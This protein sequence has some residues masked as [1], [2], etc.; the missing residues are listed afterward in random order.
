MRVDFSKWLNPGALRH[1]GY[2]QQL[3]EGAQDSFGVPAKV[4]ST[5]QQVQAR[6]TALRGSELDTVQQKWAD[7]RF[8][9]ELHY[10]AG[11][12]RKMRFVWGDLDGDGQPLSAARV[13]D[14]LDAEDPYGTGAWLVMYC[15][16]WAE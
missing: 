13:L 3:T 9:I 5:F 4:W 8:K 12:K 10:V 15:K 14:I 16:E 2:I 1:R 11:V 6:V 7:A